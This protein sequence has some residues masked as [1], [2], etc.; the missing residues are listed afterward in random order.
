M[1]LAIVS[2][3]K[4]YLDEQGS[5]MLSIKMGW[6]STVIYLE[7]KYLVTAFVPSMTL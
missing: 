3:L 7:L 4:L 1:A 5:W 2:E 6:L